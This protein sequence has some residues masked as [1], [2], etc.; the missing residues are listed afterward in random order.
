MLNKEMVE[1]EK[2]LSHPFCL[3]NNPKQNSFQE[4]FFAAL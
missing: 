2:N 4:I 3:V 1:M